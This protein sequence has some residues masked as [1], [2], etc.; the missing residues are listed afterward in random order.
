MKIELCE[1]A[2]QSWL[3]HIIGCQIVE[4]NW[5]VSPV[6]YKK[7]IESCLPYVQWF[8]QDISAKINQEIDEQ[9]KA[10]LAIHNVV[11]TAEA[12]IDSAVS[13]PDE[14]ADSQSFLYQSL[15]NCFAV[16]NKS[17]TAAMKNIF[18]KSTPNQFIT[19]CEIDVV[20][21]KLNFGEDSPNDREVEKIYIIDSAFHKGTL[22]YGD[23]PVVVLKKLIRA[24]VVS[25]IVFGSKL[26]VEIA[27]STPDCR[28]GLKQKIEDLTNI[29][30]YILKKHYS[31]DYDN[32]NI[33]LYINE[34]FA[35]EI[36]SPLKDNI[37]D[38]NNDN[39]LFMRS[40]NLAKV[41]ESRM[42][43][44]AAPNKS[45]SSGKKQTKKSSG[46]TARHAVT[47]DEKYKMA[48]EYLNKSVTLKDVEQTV[49]GYN[50]KGS[51]AKYH[52]NILG[53]DTH[54]NNVHVG[55]L[56]GCDIDDV[57][58]ATPDGKFKDTLKEIKKRGLQ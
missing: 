36:Y 16:L 56:A 30:R 24:C 35:D 5:M 43:S 52:L 40:L 22:G 11:E 42:T 47:S 55:I 31:P 25:K 27:F 39:D 34:R 33:E 23:A 44:S 50:N 37:D 20:G 4:T 45:N 2:V 10:E 15:M 8:M 54:E 6:H 1:H 14:D 53:V 12:S 38:L 17:E 58:A 26:P 57:I 46:A 51:T 32:I 49:L 21:I 48:A 29:L 7:Q 13:L 3:K 19:Q 9:T 18:G 28:P 41:A